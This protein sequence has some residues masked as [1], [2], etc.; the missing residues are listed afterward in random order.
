MGLAIDPNQPDYKRRRK[1]R[2]PKVRDFSNTRYVYPVRPKPR[3]IAWIN[4][5]LNGRRYKD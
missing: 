4:Y 1:K 3:E 2:L 5:D